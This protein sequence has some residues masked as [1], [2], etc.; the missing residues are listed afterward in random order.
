[1]AE[2]ETGNPLP[3]PASEVRL[4][5]S[6]RKLNILEK[7]FAMMPVYLHSPAHSLGNE[8]FCFRPCQFSTAEHRAL[9]CAS[10][11]LIQVLAHE[12][13]ITAIN[14]TSSPTLILS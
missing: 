6:K 14:K 2:K 10:G 11:R 9:L 12:S 8:E 3:P 7:F 4:V 5:I 1:M 13:E